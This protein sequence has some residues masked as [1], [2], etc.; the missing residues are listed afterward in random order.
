MKIICIGRNYVN[1]AKEMNAEVPQAPVFFMKPD[2]ALLPKKNPFYYP[3]FT[4]NLHHECEI[5]I[6]ITRVGKNIAEKFAHDYYDSMTLGIDFTARDL[7]DICK[8]KGL[9]WE[10]AKSFEH[11]APIGDTFIP[12]QGKNI[13][14]I[15]FHLEKNGEVVQQGNTKDMLFTVDK[16]I[17][18]I[19]QFM[20]LKIGDLIFTGTPAGVGPVQIGDHLVGYIEGEKILDLKIK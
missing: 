16:L 1:H 10:I 13:Q 3:E 11:S 8:A 18:Y 12:I 14:D 19:S 9:P 17:A 20:T 4:Q 5:V 15:Q 7:Q 6:K 2:T